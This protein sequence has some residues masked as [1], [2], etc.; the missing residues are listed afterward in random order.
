[1]M[2]ILLIAAC[3]GATTPPTVTLAPTWTPTL[4]PSPPASVTSPISAAEKIRT[5]AVLAP[6]AL[7]SPLPLS[8]SLTP[9]PSPTATPTPASSPQNQEQPVMPV[10]QTQDGR[11][12]EMGPV[13]IPTIAPLPLGRGALPVRLQ[14]PSLGLDAP[15]KE[16][17]WRVV[18]DAAGSHSEWEVV[19]NAAGHHFNSAYPGEAGNVVISGHNNIGGSVFRPVCVIGEPGV[20]FGLGDAM[21]L[22]DQKGRR[23][24]YRVNGW[25]R[26]KERNASI[27]RQE[28]NAAYM[29]P[30][31]YARLTLVT[32]WPPWS[33]THRVIVTGVL[34]DMQLIP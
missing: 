5:E 30:T 7:P 9:T 8:P 14:I 2:L 29:Q 15:V 4:L 3:R 16:M 1:M 10:G 32:C 6:T 23:F 31:A 26:L 25:R 21:I 17:G 19:D 20:D 11:V 22:T 28:A 33:N 18:Q 34:T 27:E 12:D 24:T 13:A